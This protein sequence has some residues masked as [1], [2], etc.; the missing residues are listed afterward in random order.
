VATASLVRQA[1]AKEQHIAL[2]GPLPGESIEAKFAAPVAASGQSPQSILPMLTQPPQLPPQRL[3]C[4]ESQCTK[5][6]K[7]IK[8]SLLFWVE[9]RDASQAVIPRTWT[10]WLRGRMRSLSVYASSVFRYASSA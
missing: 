7:R 6:K 5:S 1:E 2:S 10:S 9:L 3:T 8:R 4:G